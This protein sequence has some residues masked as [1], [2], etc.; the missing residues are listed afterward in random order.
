MAHQL[1]WRDQCEAAKTVRQQ[2]GL[3]PA[4]DYIIGEKLLHFA[5]VAVQRPEFAKELP[6][7]VA[8]VRS[9]F[10][11]EELVDY[12]STLDPTAMP[13]PAGVSPDWLDEPDAPAER[14]ARTSRAQ[15]ITE[16]L[17]SPRLGTA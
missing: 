1:I 5:E 6:G 14:V 11:K 4:L 2:H 10:S 17:L 13:L 3:R 16:L 15:V 7:F 8:E 12:L 9:L